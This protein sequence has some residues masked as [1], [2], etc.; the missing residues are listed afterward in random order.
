MLIM[1]LLKLLMTIYII[2]NGN[3]PACSECKFL[4]PC[5]INENNFITAK[6]EK[7]GEKNILSGEITNYYI[8]ICRK[9]P[10]LCGQNGKYFIPRVK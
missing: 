5:K 3:L 8:D 7:I 6:C 10:N 1:N 4:I 9:D 2:K